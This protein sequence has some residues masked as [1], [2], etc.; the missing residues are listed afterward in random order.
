MNR[1]TKILIVDDDLTLCD[2]LAENFKIKGAEV[3]IANDAKKG[4]EVLLKEKP[5][6]AII[7]IMMP[8]ESGLSF[9]SHIRDIPEVKNTFCI[10]LTNSIKSEYIAEALEKDV[11]VFL[12]KSNVEP[13]T[14]WKII[15]D[16][17]K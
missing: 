15:E 3:Y 7:D 6:V 10:I 4:L 12:Q 17:F 13:S 9:V 14:I 16:H 11:P 5:D 1:P 2:A 8:Y